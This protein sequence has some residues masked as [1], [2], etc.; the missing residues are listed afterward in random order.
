MTLGVPTSKFKVK[1]NDPEY[2]TAFQIDLNE[3]TFYNNRV[4]PN[5]FKQ[6]KTV[7]IIRGD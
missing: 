3:I 4:D 7:K 5:E 2:A 1:N 6:K